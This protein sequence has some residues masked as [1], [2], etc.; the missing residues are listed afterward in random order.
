MRVILKVTLIFCNRTQTIA[1][2]LSLG[3]KRILAVMQAFI[4]KNGVFGKCRN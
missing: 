3:I 4:K 1:T 2:L